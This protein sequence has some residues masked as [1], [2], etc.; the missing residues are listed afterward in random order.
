M[1]IIASIVSKTHQ[2]NGSHWLRKII[3]EQVFC[4]KRKLLT[5][6]LLQFIRL[7]TGDENV[8]IG[9]DIESETMDVQAWVF[10]EEE[11]GRKVVVV[12]TPGFDDTRDDMTDTE[13]LK[14]ITDFLVHT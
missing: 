9:Q 12:D 14:K 1:A 11:S 5:G 6:L 2:R 10:N 4:A 3:S 8:M 7:L 13:V